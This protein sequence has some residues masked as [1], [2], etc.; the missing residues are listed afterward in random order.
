MQRAAAGWAVVGLLGVA[1]WSVTVFPHATTRLE[2]V[3]RDVYLMGTRAQLATYAANR[4]EGFAHLEHA[5]RILESTERE[6]TTW[7][8]RSVISQLNRAAIGLPWRAP[9]DLCRLCDEL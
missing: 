2:L 4:D 3:H 1:T 8:D 7:S 6:L 9:D 5:L